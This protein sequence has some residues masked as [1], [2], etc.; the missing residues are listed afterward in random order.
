MSRF[1]VYFAGGSIG[2]FVCL[3]LFAVT[4]IIDGQPYTVGYRVFACLFGFVWGAL[5]FRIFYK[6][7]RP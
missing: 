5:T 4:A 3:G 7:G 6:D 2:A 1:I